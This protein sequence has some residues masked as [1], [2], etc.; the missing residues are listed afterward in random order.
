MLHPLLYKIQLW[1]FLKFTSPCLSAKGE[2]WIRTADSCFFCHRLLNLVPC[3]I[4]QHFFVYPSYIYQFASANLKLPV[5][6]LHPP[7][8]LAT[9]SLFSMSINP[10]NSAVATGLDKSVL[11]PILKKD[12]AKACSN[13]RTV[14]LISHTAK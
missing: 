13:Y 3:A 9:T 4:P 12:K 5:H 14:A 1:Y 7:S 2:A 10:E 11:I 8:L 6:L